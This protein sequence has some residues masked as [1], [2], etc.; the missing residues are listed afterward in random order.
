MENKANKI[1]LVVILI[2]TSTLNL[3]SQCI[4]GNCY[5]G[6]GT[7]VYSNGD[8]YHG[9][10]KEGQMNGMGKYEYSNG[11]RYDGQFHS[12]K[13][14]GTGTYIWKDKRS[15]V[16]QWKNDLREGYGVYKWTNS[17]TYAG[18]WTEDK[19]IS[20]DIGNT[21]ELQNKIANK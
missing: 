4:K 19:M 18:F 6:S 7:F 11:D 9:K 2:V 1:L 21:S 15:Y 3:K 17:S 10:W 13:K 5:N 8:K 16:G 14:D 20:I 12:N